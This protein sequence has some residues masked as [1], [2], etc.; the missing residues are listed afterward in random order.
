VTPLAMSPLDEVGHCVKL[1]VTLSEELK[2]FFHR[3]AFRPASS[4]SGTQIAESLRAEEHGLS[5]GAIRHDICHTLSIHICQ[6]CS[7]PSS[8]STSRAPGS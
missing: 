6:K 4:G 8:T 2:G 1:T 5:F 7:N 3:F